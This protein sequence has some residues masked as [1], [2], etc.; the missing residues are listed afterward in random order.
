MRSMLV[1]AL[2]VLMSLVLPLAEGRAATTELFVAAG[3][4]DSGPGSESAPLATLAAAQK[5]V[6]QR[7]AAGLTGD[8]TV[9]IRAGTYRLDQPSVFGPEDSGSE[10]FA[11]T[12]RAA[13]G[14]KV[15]VSGGTPVSGWTR[16]P[17][18]VW[19]AQVPGVKEGKWHFRQLYVNGRRAVRA[20]SPNA[21]DANPCWQLAGAELSG[22]RKR[23]T[24]TLAANVLSAWKNVADVEAVVFGNWEINRKR[25]ESVEPKSGLVVLAPPHA[26]GHEAIRPGP[27]RWCYF[28][29]AREMLDQPGEWYLDRTT[30]V[31]SYLPRDGEDLAKAEVVA[32]RLVELVTVKG[33]VERPVRNLHFKGLQFRHTDW[34]LPA[35]GYM[36]IQAC[37]YVSRDHWSQGWEV[38]PAAVR[39]ED[40]AGCSVED[41]L[42]TNLGGSAIELGLRCRS[43]AVLG[44]RIVDAT[45]NGVMVAGPNDEAQVPADNRVCN[46]HV[47]ACGVGHAGAVGIWVGFARGTT[48]SHNLIHGL[49]YS[50]ISVGWQWNPQPTACKANRVEYNHVYDVMN[51][52]CDGGCIYTLGFQPGTVIRGNHLHDVRRSRFAQGAP[53]NGMFIDEGSKGFLFDSNVIYSTADEHVR[54]NQCSRDWHTWRDNQFGEP[55]AVK[56][57]GKDTISKAGPEPEYRQRLGLNR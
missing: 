16:G 14:D 30:G 7:I 21:N 29:N 1:A 57:A 19:T 6:R 51:Q 40:A 56:Q 34:P 4:N 35:I 54:F 44:N 10:K 5:A 26:E 13:P 36:G 9:T 50:G 27:G 25:L 47:H 41:G 52:L 37:H 2:F 33:T 55:E 42:L 3:G 12:Y 46:N 17:D 11:I 53:N 22:D 49:P 23:Y 32:P 15:T 48:V 20:R 38:I 28:E 24:L 43:V 39:L 8:V 31:L 45:G 18:G